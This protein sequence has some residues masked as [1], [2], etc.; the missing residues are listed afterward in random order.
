MCISSVYPATTELKD[1]TV[2]FSLKYINS[3]FNLLCK[4]MKALL[5]I[6]A[7]FKKFVH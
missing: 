3:Q 1:L 5:K 6:T 4:M 7:A 2:T